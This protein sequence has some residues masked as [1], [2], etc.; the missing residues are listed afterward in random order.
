MDFIPEESKTNWIGLLGYL[1]SI[2][3]PGR[4]HLPNSIGNNKYEKLASSSTYF[5]YLILPIIKNCFLS[6]SFN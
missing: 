2:N 6:W 5:I 1:I 4:L 3:I